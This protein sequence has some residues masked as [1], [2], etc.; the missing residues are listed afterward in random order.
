VPAGVTAVGRD[1]RLLA[2]IDGVSE[3]TVEVTG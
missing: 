3:L 2:H 1:D